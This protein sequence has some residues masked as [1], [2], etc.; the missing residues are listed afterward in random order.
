LDLRVTGRRLAGQAKG[1][2]LF[3]SDGRHFRDG[4]GSIARGATGAG[5]RPRPVQLAAAAY[6]GCMLRCIGV[7][8]PRCPRPAYTWN[9]RMKGAVA[10]RKKLAAAV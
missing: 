3:G 2:F 6:P 8:D 5:P 10:M 4:L 1:P 9:T 7:D